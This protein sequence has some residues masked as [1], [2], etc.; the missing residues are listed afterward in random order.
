MG[1]PMT[2]TALDSAAGRERTYRR[3]QRRN[4]VVAALRWAVPGLGVLIAVALVVQ[5]VISNL[6]GG[7]GATAVRVEQDRV[8]IDNPRYGGVTGDGMRYDI[9]AAQARMNVNDTDLVELRD[10]VI[11]TEHADGSAVTGRAAAA[12]LDLEAQTVSVPGVMTSEDSDG[13]RAR[14]EDA[15]IE[16]KDQRLVAEGPVR[17]DFADGAVLD[18]DSVVYDADKG[19][20]EFG[21]T[22]FTH[23]GDG[24]LGAT[25]A[26]GANA[27]D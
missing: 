14:F 23:P 9:T 27:N 16:W 17:V 26:N 11:V 24:P 10:A 20:W 21:R 22:V 1:Q 2:E 13:T 12:N 5:I 19:E 25:S 8:V 3:L 6:A 15:L 18:A 7:I 4:R